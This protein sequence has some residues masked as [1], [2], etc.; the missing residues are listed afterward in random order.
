MAVVMGLSPVE[1]GCDAASAVIRFLPEVPIE[2]SGGQAYSPL[3][4]KWNLQGAYSRMKIPRH[5]LDRSVDFNP[6]SL[7]LAGVAT[8]SGHEVTGLAKA[9]TAQP[10]RPKEKPLAHFCGCG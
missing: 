2:L 4:E 9:A 7:A 8:R 10:E 5:D 1:E 6:V 3:R